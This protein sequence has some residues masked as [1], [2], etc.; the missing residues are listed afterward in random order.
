MQIDL[1]VVRETIQTNPKK[2]HQ[3]NKKEQE[4]F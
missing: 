3:K 1:Y 4:T 2:K